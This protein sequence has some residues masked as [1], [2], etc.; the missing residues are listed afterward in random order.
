[1]QPVAIKPVG[2]PISAIPLEPGHYGGGGFQG[3][4]HGGGGFGGGNFGGGHHGHHGGGG[5]GQ[6]IGHIHSKHIPQHAPVYEKPVYKAQPLPIG[7]HGKDVV[8]HVHHHV[9]HTP[10]VGGGPG[11]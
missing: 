10:S 2:H 3:G 6:G 1:V 9:H 8:E 7:I 11:E 4:H 5:Y